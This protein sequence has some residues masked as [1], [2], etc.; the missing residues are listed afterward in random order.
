MKEFEEQRS[1]DR[2]K[3]VMIL[4]LDQYSKLFSALQA[5]E[6]GK[7]NGLAGQ[8][9]KPLHPNMEKARAELENGKVFVYYE[10]DDKHGEIKA[11]IL[12]EGER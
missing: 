12:Y 11:V 3:E 10:V 1:P 8:I 9:T 2:A 6:K 5:G 7:A 4:P